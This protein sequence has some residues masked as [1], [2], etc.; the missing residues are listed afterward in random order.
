MGQISIIMDPIVDSRVD[1]CIRLVIESLAIFEHTHYVEVVSEGKHILVISIR[2]LESATF[3]IQISLAR[4][5]AIRTFIIAAIV[6]IIRVVFV[7]FASEKAGSGPSSTGVL[8]PSPGK[9]KTHR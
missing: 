4:T 9:L 6:I 1:I 3:R 8:L 5:I 7:L 2:Y